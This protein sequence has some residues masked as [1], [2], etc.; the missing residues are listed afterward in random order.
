M[1]EPEGDVELSARW[2]YEVNLTFETIKRDGGSRDKIV[3]HNKW[4]DVR[5]LAGKD[6][7]QG[8]GDIGTLVHQ[9]ESLIRF[10]KQYICSWL[11]EDDTTTIRGI[12]WLAVKLISQETAAKQPI[13]KLSGDICR[14]IQS[15]ADLLDGIQGLTPAMKGACVNVLVAT[16]TFFTEVIN[17]LRQDHVFAAGGSRLDAQLQN[18]RSEHQ[19]T[20]TTIDQQI[21]R[22]INR[23]IPLFQVD[24]RA[25]PSS[26]AFQHG[27][28]ENGGGTKL[29]FDWPSERPK[30]FFDREEQI[31]EMENHFAY[32][33]E[34]P[35][36]RSLAI[37][38]MGGVGKTSLACKYAWQQRKRIDT[39]LWFKSET[40]ASLRQSFTQAAQRLQLPGVRAD[41]H[42]ENRHVLLTWL[43]TTNKRWIV[44]FDNARDVELVKL[45][46][47][48]SGCGQVL[49]TTRNIEFEFHLTDYGMRLDNWDA[50]H[51][52]KFLE[53][54]L[55][56]ASGRRIPVHSIATENARKLAEKLEGHAL[57]ISLM[58]G[59]IHRRA[60]SVE[61]FFATYHDRPDEVLNGIFENKSIASLWNCT[62]ESLTTN[63]AT[64]LG[65]MSFLQPD[66][67][68]QS[69][70]VPKGTRRMPDGLA[71]CHRPS[72]LWDAFDALLVQALVKRV[73]QTQTFTVHRLVQSSYKHFMDQASRQRNF[74][75]ASALIHQVFP[76]Q[77]R[78]AATLWLR[79]AECERYLQHV[80]ALRDSFEQKWDDGF[81]MIASTEYCELSNMCQR[82]L[83]ETN[84]YSELELLIETNFKA[85]GTLPKTEQSI[86]LRANLASHKGQL[87]C[88]QGNYDDGLQW[89]KNSY[90][91][92]NESTHGRRPENFAWSASNVAEACASM[93]R[94]KEALE[95]IERCRNHWK[96]WTSVNDLGSSLWPPNAK[97][98]LAVILSWVDSSD[99][100]REMLLES[101]EQFKA[102]PME[103]FN[104]A[105]S[106]YTSFALGR[107]ARRDG[108]LIKAENYFNEAQNSWV[109]GDRSR[110][111]S[112]NGSCMYRL[113]CVA[114]D[115]GKLEAAVKHLRDALVVTELR[116]SVLVGEH[117]RVLFK[118]SEAL[119][120]MRGKGPE[121]ARLRIQAEAMATKLRPS[122][123]AARIE[124]DFDALVGCMWR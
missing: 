84:R 51:G 60:W 36:V 110:T 88:R 85:I 66:G 20:K 23:S 115:Q 9:L 5:A 100:A 25:T 35:C 95:W 81:K 82:Y 109:L 74:H 69:L 112:F 76:T 26:P 56:P 119:D 3:L 19:I 106:A 58:A 49:V 98:S 48:L 116:K 7:S 11:N 34:S 12:V 40:A 122:V 39:M 10:H 105:A 92:R 8:A 68:L 114:L 28:S 96:E 50:A 6:G 104:W 83:I 57:A 61:E 21:N 117:A 27:R 111:A 44:V 118:L 77:D 52:I 94:D 13:A 124:A 62:F 64:L 108:D 31:R 73:R 63:S 55:S 59:M 37:H 33:A 46:W 15:L 71:F 45:Y 90:E 75:T 91:I 22:V 1:T 113:G 41:D 4:P 42:E 53:H 32:S 17:L 29:P 121:A 2:F 72:E 43:Q 38:G 80:L 30:R 103:E 93:S 78:K 99:T 107:I 16:V 97:S 86:A 18:L 101:A 24:A 87:R 123:G 102:V 47:P 70:F 79:W 54:L 65:V 14:Q 120:R 67:V 89:L